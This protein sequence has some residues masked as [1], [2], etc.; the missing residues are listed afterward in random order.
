M[1]ANKDPDQAENRKSYAM[2][3]L[4][5]VLAG[6]PYSLQT[7]GLSLVAAALLATRVL[8]LNRERFGGADL[9]AENPD[10]LDG[11][12]WREWASDDPRPTWVRR[13]PVAGG[14]TPSSA[15]QPPDVAVEE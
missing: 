9:L 1:P 13:E 4:D 5:R 15:L 3:A 6:P 2:L 14:D 8:E 12:N 11:L 10:L 7:N